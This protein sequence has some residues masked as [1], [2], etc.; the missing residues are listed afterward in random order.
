MSEQTTQAALDR[1]P[2]AGPGKRVVGLLLDGLVWGV[3]STLLMVP[4]IV[5]IVSNAPDPEDD[6]TDPAFILGIVALYVILFVVQIVA[7]AVEA[8]LLYRRGK[9]WGMKWAGVRLIDAK[10]RGDVTRG[11]AWGRTLFGRLISGNF[12]GIGYWWALFDDQ[13][14]TLHDLVVGT[15]VVEDKT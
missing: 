7:A 10:T 8:E 5:L 12:C 4:A 13:N 3:A 6:T 15:I 11:K 2:L 9:T 14:R 1:R